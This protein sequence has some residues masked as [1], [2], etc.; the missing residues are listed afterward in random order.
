MDVVVG[1]IIAASIAWLSIFLLSKINFRKIMDVNTFRK[2]GGAA[3]VTIALTIA[4]F[5]LPRCLP[6]AIVCIGFLVSALRKGL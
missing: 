3:V 2:F 5:N 6:L 1:G 4:G